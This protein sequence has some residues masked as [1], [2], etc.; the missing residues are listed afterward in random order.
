M[1]WDFRANPDD[2]R[3]AFSCQLSVL[4]VKPPCLWKA[5]VISPQANVI[6]CQGCFLMSPAF[7][8][9]RPPPGRPHLVTG[10][11]KGE[12]M[13]AFLNAASRWPPSRNEVC[14]RCQV[15]PRMAVGQRE[16]RPPEQQEQ[17]PGSRRSYSA[18]GPSGG[19]LLAAHFPAVPRVAALTEEK[20]RKVG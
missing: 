12:M 5:Q 2:G 14:P 10:N 15:R 16:V 20:R 7:Q 13:F 18:E 4:L 1:N 3:P 11:R 19:A 8:H 17:L 6:S 9:T